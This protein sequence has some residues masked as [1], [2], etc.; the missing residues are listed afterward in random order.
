MA[1]TDGTAGSGLPV[2]ARTS[3]GGRPISVGQSAAYLD[4]GTIAGS[5]LTMETAFRLLVSTMGVPVVDAVSLCATTPARE[6]GLAGHGL[7]APGAVADLVVLD[8][9]LAVVQTYVG[10][11]LVY[12]RNTATNRSV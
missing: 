3:L 8:A 1:I 4:D 9:N 11:Q 7:I 12:S 6:L 2:G 10:G 5:V